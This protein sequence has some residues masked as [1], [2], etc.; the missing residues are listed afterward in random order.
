MIV[1]NTGNSG[2]TGNGMWRLSIL[3]PARVPSL[4]PMQVRLLQAT[5]HH[6]GNGDGNTG[7]GGPV[8]S[9]DG[10][11]NTGNSGPVGSGNTGNSGPVGSGDGNGNTGNSG[12]IGN[13]GGGVLSGNV[14][15]VLS[16]NSCTTGD[17]VC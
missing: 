3:I 7:F 17:Q 15:S 16:N 2:S 11:G 4:V 10:N 6:K 8:G 13:I 5:N 12:S 14:G 9:G 1:G